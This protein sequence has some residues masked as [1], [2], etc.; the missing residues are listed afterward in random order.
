M[1]IQIRHRVIKSVK[2]IIQIRHSAFKIARKD[3]W[4]KIQFR[5]RV[6]MFITSAFNLVL[7]LHVYYSNIQIIAIMYIVD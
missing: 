3:T 5:H 2:N 4:L 1:G 6:F 7:Y